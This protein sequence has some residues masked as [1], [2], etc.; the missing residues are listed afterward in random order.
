M[1]RC[2][3]IAMVCR[4]LLQKRL[5]VMPLVVTGQAGA[6]RDLARDVGAGGAFGV[7]Q[8]IS[9]SSTSARV[10]AGALDRMPARHGRPAWRRGSC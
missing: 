5:T 2:A 7:A 8:P 3:A 10:D 1:M 9:T 4:P 6:Q